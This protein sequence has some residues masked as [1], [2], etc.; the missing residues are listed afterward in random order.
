M[1]SLTTEQLAY[2]V[3]HGELLALLSLQRLEAMLDASHA[4]PPPTAEELAAAEATV[5]AEMQ[6]LQQQWLEQSTDGTPTDV[7]E[8]VVIVP[9]TA[10]TSSVGVDIGAEIEEALARA[11]ADI[12]ARA[13]ALQDADAAGLAP[14]LAALPGTLPALTQ[15]L[16]AG[17]VS[18]W[19]DLHDAGDV[20]LDELMARACAL[21]SSAG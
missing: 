9:A 7:N 21:G 5:Q 4:P 6:R 20:A 10:T 18:A 12:P 8:S 3:T 19:L 13:L 15:P 16:D 17:G 14:A 1:S 2:L 11:Y